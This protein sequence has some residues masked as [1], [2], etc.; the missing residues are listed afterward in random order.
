MIK[1]KHIDT[2]T[3]V[4]LQRYLGKLVTRRFHNIR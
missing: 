4:E 3:S 2:R 1:I